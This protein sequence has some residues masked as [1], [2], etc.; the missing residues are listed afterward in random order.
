MLEIAGQPNI[1]QTDLAIHSGCLGHI[2]E[3]LDASDLEAEDAIKQIGVEQSLLSVDGKA[4]WP[5]DAVW[6]D[7]EQLVAPFGTVLNYLLV[8]PPNVNRGAA[9]RL[10]RRLKVRPISE[11][12][13]LRL[14]K[15][16][17]RTLAKDAA[18]RL[19]IRADL[20]LWLAPNTES[21]RELRR[22]LSRA[23]I[24]LSMAIS[25]RAEIDEFDPPVQS[26]VSNAP[27]FYEREAGV[28]HIRGSKLRLNEWVA[29]FRAVFS[30]IERFC[31][32]ADVKPLVMTAA[33]I[34]LS[35]TREEA[36][37]AL[38][39]SDFRPPEDELGDLP[40]GEQ[41]GDVPEEETES[42]QDTSDA[43]TAQRRERTDEHEVTKNKVDGDRE[44]EATE[45][46]G[47]FADAAPRADVTGKQRDGR[48]A[49]RNADREIT[50]QQGGSDEAYK[51]KA[52]TGEFGTEENAVGE[53]S[54]PQRRSGI[55]TD[56]T[57]GTGTSKRQGQGERKSRTSRMLAYVARAGDRGEDDSEQGAGGS[58]DSKLVDIAAIR[59]ALSTRRSV[60]GGARSSPTATRATIS[61]PPALRG[62]AG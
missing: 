1:I 42:A 28:L 35:D 36:E 27:A 43:D 62:N 47:T 23:E 19:H 21:R 20:L 45:D 46:I 49:Q 54:E 16:P 22:I 59:A 60:A 11:I 2:C 14:A 6:V 9:A 5:E 44:V 3:A 39:S 37:E 13:R 38:R 58:E 40:R 61:N 10:F 41:L 50:I 17:D 8:Q 48:G 30:D 18:D 24:R 56:G 34:M 57:D 15:E 33:V 12:A 32:L 53:G 55:E 4:V 31:P 52:G 7:S 29:A 25:I 51:S 26:A